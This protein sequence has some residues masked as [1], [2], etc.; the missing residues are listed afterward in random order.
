MFQL[1]KKSQAQATPID[2]APKDLRLAHRTDTFADATI[3]TPEGQAKKGVV[4]DISPCGARL[5]FVATESLG[6][7]ISVRIPRLQ[8]QRKARIRWAT[9]TDIGVEFT[10]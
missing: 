6:E 1:F 8:L 9:R 2:V 4:L 10:D 7:N 3:R 5:R